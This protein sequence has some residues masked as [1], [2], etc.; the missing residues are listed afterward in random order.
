MVLRSDKMEVFFYLL[1]IC[2]DS[3]SLPDNLP[4]SQMEWWDQSLFD[5]LEPDEPT[6]PDQGPEAVE[7]LW[8]N[9]SFK[10]AL[11]GLHHHQIAGVPMDHPCSFAVISKFEDTLDVDMYIFA[12]HHNQRIMY[13][14]QERLRRAKRV[15]LFYTKHSETEGQF[16]A[17]TKVPSFLARSYF[18]HQC[19]KVFNT[20]DKHMCEEFCRTCKRNKCL[21]GK[22]T[23]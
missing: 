6:K 17:I 10:D 19:L 11:E 13:P 16:D 18:C 20:R 9:Y 1:G 23:V 3:W 4:N 22:N 7:Q 8:W 21:R 14:N 12:A 5:E 2:W 15:Y